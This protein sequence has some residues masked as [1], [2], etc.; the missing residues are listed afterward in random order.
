MTNPDMLFHSHFAEQIMHQRPEKPGRFLMM[1]I[2]LAG[3]IWIA[4]ES[5]VAQT[6]GVIPTVE[7]L[8]PITVHASFTLQASLAAGDVSIALTDSSLKKYFP[9][10]KKFAS[11]KINPG[12]ANEETVVLV[13]EAAG[14]G[15]MLALGGLSKNHSAGE[16]VSTEIEQAVVIFGYHN[17]TT[18]TVTLRIGQPNNFFFN[19]PED[20]GQPELFLPGVHPRAFAALWD[21]SQS[22]TLTWILDDQF[23]TASLSTPRCNA[24]ALGLIF[25][26]QWN[27]AIPYV[28]NDV[29][30]YQGSSWIAR[31]GNENVAPAEGDD[32][33]LLVQ[34]GE[35]G[36]AGPQGTKGDAG[37]Q[38]P[39]GD[40]GQQGLPGPT[41]PQGIQGIQGQ[42]GL[43]GPAGPQGP[44]GLNWRGEWNSSHSYVSNDGA[45]FNGSSWIAMRANT[46]IPPAEGQDWTILAKKGETGLQ[47][48]Q[49]PQGN[50]GATGTQGPQGT[51]GIQGPQGI[52]GTSILLDSITV[53]TIT[54]ANGSTVA[55]AECPLRHLLLT[56][57][58]ECSRG[59]LLSNGP[60]NSTS[61]QVK[62]SGSGV[63]ARAICVPTRQR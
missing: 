15:A 13:R 44:K 14:T 27:P 8:E 59:Y 22:A 4:P 33:L 61:W 20:R 11:V 30:S 46:N 28:V 23:V 41:G 12:G 35:P 52:P 53:E 21:L 62:C 48:A 32:W 2:V 24:N 36:P 26:G 50:I 37:A 6:T 16:R 7:C 49:G 9:V 39:K 63:T 25:K 18:R 45:S 17:T 47:G 43:Q 60:L 55:T 51:P 5:A 34:R 54:P 10:G 1:A 29:V 40:T 58:G 38:G 42:T 3:L 31:R 19:A 57:G 56:G